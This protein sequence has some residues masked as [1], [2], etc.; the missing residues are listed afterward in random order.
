MNIG[1]FDSG[2]GGLSVLHRAKKMIAGENFIYYADES[3]VPYG[4]KSPEE[5]RRFADEILNFMID[6]GADAV[7]I[8]CNTATSAMT[9]EYRKHFDIPIIGMEPA[10]K[11]AIDLYD[12]EDRRILVAA[13]PVTI[14]GQ[15]LHDLVEHVDVHHKVD[16]I[17]LPALVRF[18]E[19]GIF[20]SHDV[21]LYMRKAL[22]EYDLENYGTIV[23]GCTHFN[24]FKNSFK[25]I[26][27][28]KIHFADGN[29]GTIRQLMRL[30][31]LKEC[32]KGKGKTE[33]Y[34]SGKPV[35]KTGMELIELCLSKLDE[36][37]G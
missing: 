3:H 1:I 24:Y 7:V 18:A 30:L 2:I 17:G 25:S 6:K 4:E 14:R 16:L 27:G 31:S 34:F 37:Y 8:A 11:K 12:E 20:D 26:F 35:D 29:E 10:V 21:N 22:S 28:R 36:V 23:L 9:M 19:K 15:K 5:I 13:T 32:S 33:F